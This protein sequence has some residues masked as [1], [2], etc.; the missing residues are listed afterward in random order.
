MF[1]FCFGAQIAKFLLDTVLMG[2]LLVLVDSPKEV[3]KGNFSGQVQTLALVGFVSM[4]LSDVRRRTRDAI[5]LFVY[6]VISKQLQ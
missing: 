5:P 4:I 6:T 1:L 2:P 3:V